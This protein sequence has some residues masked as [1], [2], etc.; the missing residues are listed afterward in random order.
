M[1]PKNRH[2]LHLVVLSVLVIMVG[3]AQAKTESISVE[4]GKELTRTINLASGDRTLISFTVLGPAPSSLNFYIILPDGTTSDYGETSQFK[5]DFFTSVEGECQLTFDNSNSSDP[6][7]VT[8]NYEVEHY[9]LGIP[10]MI[11]L[12][13]A[14]AILLL[15][16]VAGYIIM[17]KYG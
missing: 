15:F 3:I 12:L 5:T 17:G 16:V 13:I 6:K 8:L 11:F 1:K 10:Q 4:P 14:I 7:L 9:I 2:L